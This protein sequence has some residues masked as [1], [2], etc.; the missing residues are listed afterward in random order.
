MGVKKIFLLLSTL[1]CIQAYSQTAIEFVVVEEQLEKPL[2]SASI[3]LLGIKNNSVLAFGFTD[4]YGKKGFSNITDDSLRVKVSYLGYDTEERIIS[5]RIHQHTIK[6]VKNTVELKEVLITTYPKSF[7]LKEDTISYNIKSVRDG[8]ERNLGDALKKLPGID[9]DE[10]GIVS[11]KGKKIDQIL[12]D[13][14]TLFGNKHQMTTQNLTAEMVDNAQVIS[15]YSDNPLQKRGGKTVLN[16]SM[17]EKFKNRFV[18]N[19]NA[20]LGL[21]EKYNS[22]SNIFRFVNSGNIGIITNLNNLGTSPLTIEDYIEM[23]GGISS[24]METSGGNQIST[25]DFNQFPKFIFNKD[26]FQQKSN[27]FVALNFTKNSEKWKLKS[28]NFLNYNRQKENVLKNR[29]FINQNN[30]TFTEAFT[31]ISEGLLNSTYLNLR[32]IPNNK[33]YWNLQVNINPNRDDSEESVAVNQNNTPARYTTSRTNTNINLGYQLSY[34]NKLKENWVLSS[35]LAQ[36]YTNNKKDI[37]IISENEAAIPLLKSESPLL[38]DYFFTDYL[39]NINTNLQYKRNKDQ[40]VISATYQN[41]NQKLVTTISGRPELDN[42]LNLVNNVYSATFKNVNFITPKVFL[43]A[44]NKLSLYQNYYLDSVVWPRY[45]PAIS[46]GYLFAFAHK[47][48]L[49]AGISN[50]N[51]GIAYLA[52]N[53]LILD[54]RTFIRSDIHN[55]DRLTN[56]RF[57]LLN[58]LF[59]DHKRELT[60]HADINYTYRK[61]KIIQTNDFS[62]GY[63]ANVYLFS[64]HE[65]AYSGKVILDKRFRAIPFSVKNLLHF[66]HINSINY[67]SKNESLLTNNTLVYRFNLFSHFKNKAFQFESGVQYNQTALEQSINNTL[68]EIK[69]YNIFLKLKGVVGGSIIWDLK[70][71][72]ILQESPLGQNRLFFVSPTISKDSKNKK[73][74]Y[75]LHG[76]NVLN[77]QNNIKLISRFTNISLENTQSAMLDGYI[78]CGIKY[79]L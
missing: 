32:Y 47:V 15:N 10:N 3:Q 79:N 48:T 76:N 24:F 59:F 37:N 20:D 75:S 39:L 22:H 34:N 72:R 63:I 42:N 38:Q 7:T 28:Y 70:F 2:S 71:T 18:G 5:T 67:V 12:V 56:S 13:G 45:E 73:W 26:D 50:Q 33:N 44:E 65:N 74:T 49:S 77:L 21:L 31:D 78:L 52:D 58:Y 41:N 68:S 35:E 29:T 46:L 69:N 6:L 4:N 53:P 62:D 36:S 64:P 1:F 16:L 61:N 60:L 54:Y 57:A 17:N 27:K 25:L 51:I 8:T 43:S 30:L 11:H 55:Y 9:V 19:V 66:S 40:Y 14:N 23:R